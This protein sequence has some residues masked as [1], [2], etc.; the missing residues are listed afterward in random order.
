[1]S[2]NGT[3]DKNLN[4]MFSERQILSQKLSQALNISDTLSKL[5]QQIIDWRKQI[6]IESEKTN[7]SSESLAQLTNQ[8]TNL[9]LQLAKNT[10][11]LKKSSSQVEDLK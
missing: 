6:Q 7:M 4:S 5:Q 2:I 8:Y 10:E 1:M 11:Y 9:Q 3:F